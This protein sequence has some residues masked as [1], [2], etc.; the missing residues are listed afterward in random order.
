MKRVLFFVIML[1]SVNCVKINAIDFESENFVAETVDEFGDNT[2]KKK[3]GILA[4]GAFSN[5]ATTNS[6]AQLLINVMEEHSWINLYEYCSGHPTRE[7]YVI[8][9]IDERGEQIKCIDYRFGDRSN[10]LLFLDMC[11]NNNVIKIK[12][13]EIGNYA[14]MT[15]V[16]K[17]TNAKEFY[18]MV[19]AEFPDKAL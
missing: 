16:F 18:N 17:I 6:C 19:V 15:A 11:K 3:V 8:A 4:K 10:L 9:F 2:G 1:L 5:S 14:S 13:R 12:I 7:D